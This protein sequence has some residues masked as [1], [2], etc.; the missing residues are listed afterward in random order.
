LAAL[1]SDTGGSIRQPASF[2]GV[3]GLKPTYGAVSRSGLIAMGSS[4][5][6][7]GPLATN[8]ADAELLFHVIAGKDPLDMTSRE[9]DPHASSPVKTIGVPRVFLEKGMDPDVGEHFDRQLNI[10]ARQGYAVQDVELPTV[11]YALPA[12]YIVMPAEASTNLARYDGVRYG[13]YEEGETLLEDYTKTR[14][15]FGSEVKRRI[16]IGTYVLSSGY[17]DAYYVRAN[18]VRAKIRRDF[19]RAFEHVDVIVTPTSPTPAFKAG[20]K[21]D[22]LSMYLAD[23][24]TV[25]A[26]LTG[27]PALS[28]P[29]GTVS[30]EGTE[31]P[32]GFQIIGPD[33]GEARLFDLGK[34]VEA[35]A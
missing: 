14:S 13:R 15:A 32:V 29:M 26:N 20:E 18:A 22:P 3:V 1:G 28:V 24:F 9:A 34:V 35:A 19:E 21:S 23:I 31:L 12:Y 8:V 25:P 17:Y 4:L 2:C 30:R 27:M 33:M 5:D 11:D 16:L 6:V 10:L 7:I